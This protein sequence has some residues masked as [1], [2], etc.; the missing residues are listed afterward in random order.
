[1]ANAFTPRKPGGR[2]VQ[3]P[4]A[5]FPCP[6]CHAPAGANYPA[7]HSCYRSIEALWLADWTALLAVEGIASGSEDETL[8][9]HVVAAD[10]DAHPWT[11]VDIAHTFVSCPACG[12]E[13]CGGPL[14]CTHCK[15]TF[16]NLWA[17]DME[18]GYQGE[19]TLNEHMIR[20]GRLELRHPHRFPAGTAEIARWLMPIGLT[21]PAPVEPFKMQAI[22][23][24][25]E[26]G[27]LTREETQ[28]ESSFEAIFAKIAR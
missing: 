7:C 17:Y 28:W 25:F 6:T 12:A 21:N 15:F 1:M 27:T 20:V 23:A 22:Y 24:A 5:V 14:T 3:R 18:A 19:M 4:A 13:L 11:V 2:R 9:A 26:A 16:E 8:M 10:I